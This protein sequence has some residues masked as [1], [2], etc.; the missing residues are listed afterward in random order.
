MSDEVRPCPHCGCIETSERKDDSGINY[1]TVY[2]IYCL[3]C[4]CNVGGNSREQ[5]LRIWNTRHSDTEIEELKK[6]ISAIKER[7]S[8]ENIEKLWGIVQARIEYLKT[9]KSLDWQII[10]EL[11]K[12]KEQIEELKNG[13]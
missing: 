4:L 10:Q 11:E 12:V 7:A 13:M 2:Y 6:E 1:S 5:A 9:F 3:D 8:E